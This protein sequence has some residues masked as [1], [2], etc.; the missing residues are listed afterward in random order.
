MSTINAALGKLYNPAGGSPRTSDRDKLAAPRRFAA[1]LGRKLMV[2]DEG[3]KDGYSFSPIFFD[4]FNR[5]VFIDPS[6]GS[7]LG[8]VPEDGNTGVFSFFSNF[9][10]C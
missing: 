5:L 8:A 2:I 10:N 9:Y 3:G 1:V 4:M 6:N 7:Y